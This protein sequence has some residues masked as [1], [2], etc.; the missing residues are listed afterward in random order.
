MNQSVA[1][2]TLNAPLSPVVQLGPIDAVET[3]LVDRWAD[4][5]Q[6]TYRFLALLREFDF[7]QGWKAYGCNDCAE[8]MDFKL[9]ISRKTALEK[10]RVANALWFVPKIDAAFRDGALSY[11][12]VRALTRIADE[13]NE[14]DLV[15]R[16]QSTSAGALEKYVQTAAARGRARSVSNWLARSTRV[17]PCMCSSTPAK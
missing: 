5:S 4:V 3:A 12:Q 16:A 6:A 2:N 14:E 9:K 15:Q 1:L 7:R 10:V 13:T 17:E 11:S 8:W